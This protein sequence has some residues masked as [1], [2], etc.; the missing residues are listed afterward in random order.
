LPIL[1]KR[2]WNQTPWAYLPKVDQWRRVTATT[3]QSSIPTLRRGNNTKIAPIK[4]VSAWIR[5]QR[6]EPINMHWTER[7]TI[8]RHNKEEIC[9][10]YICVYIYI[11]SVLELELRAYTLSH[12]TSPF[13]VMVSFEIRSHKLFA[14]ADF[15]PQSSWSLP[16]ELLELQC[17][18]L[19][20]GNIYINFYKLA[21]FIFFHFLFFYSCA[22]FGYITA[23]LTLYQI[24][25]I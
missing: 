15:E 8:P 24:Y 23:F 14:W 10:K 21:S 20:S 3:T 25:D 2:A 1:P 6:N 4:R 7:E 13:F 19:A 9:N 17:E 5:N 12:S 16:L 22:H 11:F 18:P